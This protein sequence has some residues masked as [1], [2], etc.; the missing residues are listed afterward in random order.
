[1][2]VP[3]AIAE[4]AQAAARPAR[5]VSEEAAVTAGVEAALAADRR[6]WACRLRTRLGDLPSSAIAERE[7]VAALAEE[8]NAA[9]DEIDYGV[10]RVS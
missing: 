2:S 10:G 5:A 7:I 1:M 4:A 3:L 9:A 8:L 6:D